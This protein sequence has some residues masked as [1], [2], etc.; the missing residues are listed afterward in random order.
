LKSKIEKLNANEKTL[1]EEFR[2]LEE[3]KNNIDKVLVQNIEEI[4]DQKN[5]LMKAKS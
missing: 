5:A 2:G 3:E 4:K 1:K